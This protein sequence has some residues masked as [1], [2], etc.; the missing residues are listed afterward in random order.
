MEKKEENLVEFIDL[1]EKFLLTKGSD[2]FH[3]DYKRP[4]WPTKFSIWVQTYLDKCGID[5]AEFKLIDGKL[6]IK[7]VKYLVGYEELPSPYIISYD[8][9]DKSSPNNINNVSLKLLENADS[10]DLTTSSDEDVI[11]TYRKLGPNDTIEV[12]DDG[13]IEDKNSTFTITSSEFKS[14][15]KEETKLYYEERKKEIETYEKTRFE[16]IDKAIEDDL[17]NKDK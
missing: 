12:I 16:E 3:M 9:D 11:T 17:N 13:E 5:S 2:G 10:V 15:I 7:D 8:D 14:I 4:S 6:E 1:F